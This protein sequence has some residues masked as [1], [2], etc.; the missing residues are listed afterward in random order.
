MRINFGEIEW[1][2]EDVGVSDGDED[3]SHVSP[4]RPHHTTLGYKTDRSIDSRIPFKDRNIRLDGLTR[5]ALNIGERTISD[6]QL[7]DPC[8]ESWSSRSCIGDVA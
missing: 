3:L 1:G 5:I 7:S 8:D 4:C 6:V 2:E